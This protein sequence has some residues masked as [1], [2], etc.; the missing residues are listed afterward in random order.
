MEK[1][2]LPTLAYA[3]D[4]LEP[5]Y[6]A[7]TVELHHSKHHQGYVTGLNAALDKLA[8]ARTSGDHGAIKHLEREL[9]FHGSGHLLHSIFWTNLSPNGGGTP[10]G[11]LAAAIDSSFGSFDAFSAQLRAATVAVEGSGWGVLAAN[12][13]CGLMILQVEKHQN[14]I[15]PGWTPILVLDVWEHA[16]YLKYQNRRAAFVN[17]IMGHLV[18]WDD[19]AK[20]YTAVTK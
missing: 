14:Q 20:R 9:A 12:R 8:A 16:Y 13:Q 10:T 4:A 3:Y 18:N 15:V 6:D 7:R 17:A 11:A 1:H 19:V 2:E 5:H